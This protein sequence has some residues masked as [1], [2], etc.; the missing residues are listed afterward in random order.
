MVSAMKLHRLAVL[1]LLVASFALV[2]C[3]R[4]REYNG[5]G[6]WVIGKTKYAHAGGHCKPTAGVVWCGDDPLD[7]HRSL[8]LGGQSANVGLY[9]DHAEPSSEL[10][11]IELEI[12]GCNDQSLRSWMEST[13]GKP[14][15]TQGKK[16]YWKQRSTY[17][18][19]TMP[20]DD[21]SCIINMVKADDAKRISQLRGESAAKKADAKAGGAKPEAKPANPAQ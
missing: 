11:E 14:T 7:K 10:I 6:K 5:F 12:R 4:K 9:F 2:G 19:A 15:E 20:R 1:S 16:S 21:L 3:K 17:V 13:F 8:D 18:A